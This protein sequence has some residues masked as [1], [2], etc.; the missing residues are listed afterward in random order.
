MLAEILDPDLKVYV[1]W[2]PI[3]QTDDVD[4]ALRS[5]TFFPDSR[6]TQFWI[7]DRGMAEIFKPPLD[8]QVAPAWDVYLLYSPGHKWETDPP[9]PDYFMHQLREPPADQRLN[10]AT[11]A[12]KIREFLA[13]SKE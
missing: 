4:S 12:G 5:S 8:L 1:V 3:L 13:A 10:G 6:V 9:R 11:L 2:E 7:E